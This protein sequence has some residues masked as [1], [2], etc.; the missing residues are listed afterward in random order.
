MSYW[1]VFFMEKENTMA[2]DG[3]MFVQRKAWGYNKL[4]AAV[5]DNSPTEKLAE[6]ETQSVGNMLSN[7][8]AIPSL[9]SSIDQALQVLQSTTSELSLETSNQRCARL[10]QSLH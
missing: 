4:C 9:K 10:I 2:S 7:G 5:C 1:V 3:D 6:I 8:H